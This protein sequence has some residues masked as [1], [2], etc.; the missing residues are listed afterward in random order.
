MKVILSSRCFQE[1]LCQLAMRFN[2]L[3][4]KFHIKQLIQ[5]EICEGIGG[6]SLIIGAC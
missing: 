3:Q 6:H 1:F 5:D 2:Q 4:Q